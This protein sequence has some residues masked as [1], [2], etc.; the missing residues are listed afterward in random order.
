MNKIKMKPLM[1]SEEGD[2]TINKFNFKVTRRE[3]KAVPGNPAHISLSFYSK[4]KVDDKKIGDILVKSAEIANNELEKA[5]L[6]E[7][8]Y[9]PGSL[10]LIFKAG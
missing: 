7:I 1:S 9:Y 5:T 4:T 10:R 8:C 6:S 2:V 3:Y